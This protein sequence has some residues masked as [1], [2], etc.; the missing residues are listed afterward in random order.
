MRTIVRRCARTMTARPFLEALEARALPYA[1]PVGSQLAVATLGS[2]SDTGTATALTGTTFPPGGAPTPQFAVAYTDT[3][4]F[5]GHFGTALSAQ[6]YDAGANPVPAPPNNHPIALVATDGTIPLAPTGFPTFTPLAVGG[7]DDGSFYVL[8]QAVGFGNLGPTGLPTAASLIVIR[9]DSSGNFQQARTVGAVPF[10]DGVANARLA[11]APAGGFVVAWDQTARLNSSGVAGETDTILASAFD[12]SMH[13]RFQNL[14]LASFTQMGNGIEFSPSPPPL[15]LAT[16]NSDHF[17]VAYAPPVVT[18]GSVFGPSFPTLVARPFDS[19][20]APISPPITVVDESGSSGPTFLDP[21]VAMGPDADFIVAYAGVNKNAAGVVFPGVYAQLYDDQGGAGLLIPVALDIAA[22]VGSGPSQFY[23]TSFV[24]APVVAE[25]DAGEFAVAY[26]RQTSTIPLGG[27]TGFASA[28]NIVVRQ[29]LAPLGDS[30]AADQAQVVNTSPLNGAPALSLG[31]N[32]EGD[33]DIA[34]VES[35]FPRAFSAR[36]FAADSPSGLAAVD[37]T[38]PAASLLQPFPGSS[39]SGGSGSGNSG[40]GS[41]ASGSSSSFPSSP[42]GSSSEGAGSASP[43]SGLSNSGAAAAAA[44]FAV[45]ASPS[46][47]GASGGASAVPAPT[48]AA[49]TAPSATAPASSAA[50]T[51]S[52]PTSAALATLTTQARPAAG[53]SAAAGVPLALLGGVAGSLAGAASPPGSGFVEAAPPPLH[54]L[55]GAGAP[56]AVT[57]YVAQAGDISGVVF[58]DRN[59]NGVREAGEEGLAG[60]QVFIDLHGDGQL[61]ADDPVTVTDEQGRYLFRGLPLNRTYVVRQVKPA[62]TAQTLPQRDQAHEVRLSDNHPAQTDVL[63]GAAPSPARPVRP[64][65][66]PETDGPPEPMGPPVKPR[67]GPDP[68]DRQES[69]RAAPPGE[70]SD[71]AFQAGRFWRLA[72]APA[73]L[74]GAVAL[75]QERRRRRPSGA[76]SAAE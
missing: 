2:V 23:V 51:S 12:V 41:G 39:S 31:M 9:Y 67:A 47:S 58:F 4:L 57:P 54:T 18:A 44:A 29:F 53:P 38:L 13:P 20:G 40:S 55:A 36:L 43:S 66:T 32:G 56:T 48:S 74:V 46:P 59:K 11:V 27:G 69:R 35:S 33:F 30:V 25:N 6:R 65:G 7:S 60:R 8:G 63:F 49:Q 73:A 5:S 45:A 76:R 68:P 28:G 64:V 24:S 71:A 21:S 1:F 26:D 34:W 61:H 10:G 52:S 22:V 14:Q 3:G 17:V 70:A 62:G 37:L 75:R 72:V 16:S 42:S 15:A 50:D 19:S